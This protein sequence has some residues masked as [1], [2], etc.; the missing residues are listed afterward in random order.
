[1]ASKAG[2]EIRFPRVEGYTQAVRNRITVDWRSVP[3]LVLEPG[4]IPPEVEV[5]ALSIT[6][7]GRLTL[8]GPGRLDQVKLNEF[9]ARHRVQELVFE[10]A[11]ALTAEM[12]A[13][14]GSV[15]PHVLF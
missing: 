13:Q 4:R 7:E 2:F 12:T 9:R 6:N 5:K 14:G 1:M 3:S 8:C 11:R 10:L 15:P